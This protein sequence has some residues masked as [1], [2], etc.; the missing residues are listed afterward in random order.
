MTS[1]P[2]VDDLPFILTL[3]LLGIRQFC[4]FGN[5]SLASQLAHAWVAQQT[6]GRHA[7]VGVELEDTNS[8]KRYRLDLVQ[9]E[10]DSV[11]SLAWIELGDPNP[12]NITP[13][14]TLARWRNRVRALREPKPAK[15]EREPGEAFYTWTV[16]FEVDTKA[17]RGFEFTNE[18]AHEMVLH[19]LSWAEPQEARAKV[20]SCAKQ[21]GRTCYTVQLEIDAVW[22]ADGFELTNE[23]ALDMLYD[24]L[25]WVEAEEVSARILQAPE[26]ED[27][28]R[29]QGYSEAR[30]AAHRGERLQR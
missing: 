7:S 15:S 8:G 16:L 12:E 13:A 24:T 6:E 20:L 17:L 11:P 9:Y 29:E 4:K 25:R 22:V 27:V 30:I 2:S 26:H 3:E 18:R 23:R 1:D 19:Y 28:L 21:C 5:T 14:A 10:R